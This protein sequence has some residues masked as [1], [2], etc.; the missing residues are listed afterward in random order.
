MPYE[1]VVTFTVTE[2]GQPFHSTTNRWDNLSY[3]D[4]VQLEKLGVQTIQSIVSMGE[5]KAK[6][7]AVKK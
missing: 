4:V 2:G 5:A 7:K 3:E 6:E 1:V